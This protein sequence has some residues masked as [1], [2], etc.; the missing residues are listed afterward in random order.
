MRDSRILRSTPHPLSSRPLL[1][2][3]ADMALLVGREEITADLERALDRSLNVLVVG[4]HGAGRTSL[5]RALEYRHRS[6]DPAAPQLVY[7]RAAGLDDAHQILLR[8]LQ[9]CARAEPDHVGP[10]ADSTIALSRLAAVQRERPVVVLLDD[11]APRPGNILFGVLRDEL[12]ETRTTWVVT[13]T[14]SESTTLLAPPANAFFETILSLQDLTPAEATTMLELRLPH[15]ARDR[16]AGVAGPGGTPRAL[17]ELVRQVD[18]EAT[19]GQDAAFDTARREWDK[20]LARLGEPAS[21]LASEMRTIVR[22]RGRERPCSSAW[23]DP[24]PRPAGPRRPRGGG[25]GRLR[26]RA[27][28]RAGPTQE[29]LSPQDARRVDHR[30]ARRPAGRRM[31]RERLA[32]LHAANAFDAAPLRAVMHRLHVP[33]DKHHRHPRVRASAAHVGAGPAPGG[34][35]GDQQVG[36]DHVT[37]SVLGPT[38][39][40]LAPIPVSVSVESPDI[41]TH[42]VAFAITS[43]PSCAAG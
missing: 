21:L 4:E 29:A 24:A 28:D 20:T 22:S 41:A 37:E 14:P 43:S 12:W 40:G 23:E 16:L 27:T 35:R 15:V 10:A 11:V 42:P 17:M 32:A 34:A 39:E 33:F 3:T 7:V 8:V 36:Q 38:V 30:V 19:T 31:S 13:A 25:S 26:R 1:G 2:S 5:L 9:A 6:D 18:W